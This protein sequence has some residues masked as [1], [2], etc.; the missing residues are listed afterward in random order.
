MD[1]LN[2]NGF[3]L[4]KNILSTNDINFALS[5]IDVVNHTVQYDKMKTFIYDTMLFKIK[6]YLNLNTN[7]TEYIKYRVSNN[8]NSVDAGSFHS[9]IVF[10]GDSAY[11]DKYGCPVF[12]CLTYLDNTH[13]EVI[14]QSHKILK[15]NYY[16]CYKEYKK[17]ITLYV[18]QGDLL[19][20]Y[21]TLL[22]RG[23]FT[24]KLDNRRLI[25]VFDVFF[26]LDLY[27]FMNPYIY[28]FPQLSENKTKNNILIKIHKNKGVVLTFIN[29]LAY[30]NAARGYGI[31]YDTL[32]KININKPFVYISSEGM[33]SR[34]IPSEQ[35]KWIGPINKYILNEKYKVQDL[36]EDILSKYY[37]Y[38][39]VKTD[40]ELFL[41]FFLYFILI[42]I[43]VTFSKKMI[44]N[45][46]CK[47]SKS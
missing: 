45:K 4:I 12:T 2:T 29:L 26:N 11:F 41:L 28:N 35:N 5:S 13:M 22:H 40:M 43:M 25:Q 30:I 10:Q 8:N 1:E 46:S 3:L 33:I 44:F 15:Y 42:I 18:E 21:S 19:I 6:T 14:P 36:P 7:F 37:Y 16:D 20:F 23:I 34:F 32:N 9:D 39:Y 27:N 24:E 31:N 38:A 17:K 47:K